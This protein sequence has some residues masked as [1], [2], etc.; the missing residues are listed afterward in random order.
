MTNARKPSLRAVAGIAGASAGLWLFGFGTEEKSGERPTAICTEASED[1]QKS[2]EGIH[3]SKDLEELARI[4]TEVVQHKTHIPG[5]IL[6]SA[7]VVVI[8]CDPGISRSDM[9]NSTLVD[10]NASA[11]LTEEVRV[12]LPFAMGQRNSLI[13]SPPNERHEQVVAV[14]M[15]KASSAQA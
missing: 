4:L 14:C 12:C 3:F 5:V 6:S 1:T 7:S 13:Q 8:D 9:V 2:L 11:G 10:V 15:D